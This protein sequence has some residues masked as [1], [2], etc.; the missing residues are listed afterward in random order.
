MD[1][2]RL[3]KTLLKLISMLSSFQLQELT[4]GNPEIV[5]VKAGGQQGGETKL[6]HVKGMKVDVLAISHIKEL[7]RSSLCCQTSICKSYTLIA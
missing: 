5:D 4:S 3:H 2:T 1:S 6:E 7:E